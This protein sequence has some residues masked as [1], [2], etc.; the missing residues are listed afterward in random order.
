MAKFLTTAKAY[1]AIEDII[2]NAK[3]ELVIISPYLQIPERLLERLK[4]TDKNV[5]ITMICRKKSL[6]SEEKEHI[7]QMENVKLGYLESLH[8]KCF[9]NEKAMVITSLN[10]YDY[11]QQNNREMGILIERENDSVLFKDAH[12][13]AIFIVDSATLE[14][15]TSKPSYQTK[16]KPRFAKEKAT[17]KEGF[18]IR[19]GN[20][21]PYNYWEPYCPTHLKSWLRFKNEY[22]PENFC[23]KCSKEMVSSRRNPICSNCRAEVIRNR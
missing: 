2:V 14:K 12:N 5:S 3:A 4:Y 20:N 6:K 22:Y 19:C 1:A 10:L 18:C 17:E 13:E 21:I 8:A 9:F 16:L 7:D 23:H 15:K 11:S